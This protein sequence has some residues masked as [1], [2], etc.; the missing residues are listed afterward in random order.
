MKINWF[1]FIA[2]LGLQVNAQ[3]QPKERLNCIYIIIFTVLVNYFSDYF[4]MYK[5]VVK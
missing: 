4:R 2:F 5:L 1:I 3:P